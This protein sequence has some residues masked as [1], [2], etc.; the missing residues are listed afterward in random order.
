MD[1]NQLNN[2]IIART[3]NPIAFLLGDIVKIFS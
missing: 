3:A 1:N 2:Y